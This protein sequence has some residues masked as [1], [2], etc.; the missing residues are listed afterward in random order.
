VD[1]VRL[2]FIEYLDQHVQRK[3]LAVPFVSGGP[4]PESHPTA[5]PTQVVDA[6]V[7]NATVAAR[8]TRRREY[9]DGN[10]LPAVRDGGRSRAVDGD[11][12]GEL[13]RQLPGRIQAG[14]GRQR[15]PA[16]G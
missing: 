16:R 15:S 3:I 13:P 11:G 10:A 14:T 2:E 5:T 6:I 12:I 8:C 7:T 1:Y 9:D 4:L